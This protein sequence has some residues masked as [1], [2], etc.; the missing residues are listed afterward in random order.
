MLRLGRPRW[1][2]HPREYEFTGQVVTPQLLRRPGLGLKD[3]HQSVVDTVVRTEGTGYL[4]VVPRPPLR[5]EAAGVDTRPEA[6]GYLH[7]HQLGRGGHTVDVEVGRAESGPHVVRVLPESA[8]CLVGLSK[9]LSHSCTAASKRP[10]DR[11]QCPTDRKSEPMTA[12][13]L[14]CCAAA[15]PR[16]RRSRRGL[17]RPP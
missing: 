4:N 13:L 17:P 3:H 11:R 1:L 12:G 9:E 5:R 16:S 8:G 2:T 6:G 10:V 14:D 7:A 15:N